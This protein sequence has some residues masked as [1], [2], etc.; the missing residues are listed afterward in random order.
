V[1]KRYFTVLSLFSGGMGLDIGLDKTGRFKHLACVEKVPAFCE[2]IR[3][4]RDAGRLGNRD[5][6]VY[7][8]DI[9]EMQPAQI[10]RDLQLVPGDLDLLVGGPPCQA[11]SVFGKRRGLADQRGQ[12][13]LEFLRFV[14]VLQPRA[15]LMENMR[16][17]LSMTTADSK[18]KG[19]LFEM[20]QKGFD[21][22][23]Y[24]SDCFVVNAVNYGAP[25]IRE[26]IL[27]I[28]NR[29]I[30]VADFPSP[31]HSD[32]PDDHLAPFRTLGDA[33]CGKPDPDPSVMQFSVR[34]QKYL[35]MVPAGGNWRS[36]PV[37][38]QKESM[39]KTFYLKGGRSAYWRKLS[40]EF[41]CPTVITMPNHAG[42]SMCHPEFLRPLTVG[43]CALVQEFPEGWAFAGTPGEKYQQVGN[44]V[45]ILLGRL[46]GDAVARL[47]D[48][49]TKGQLPDTGPGKPSQVV[50]IRPHV[51]TRW[52]WKDGEV[53]E[54]RPYSQRPR[55][56]P[57]GNDGPTLFDNLPLP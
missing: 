14:E 13:I 27:M 35:A 40:Y 57:R 49:I 54:A 15:F 17:L 31:M 29:G 46:A 47:L 7:Q 19:S 1:R 45:P 32:R 51:R 9:A 18:R 56:K 41:P 33:I 11:F 3:R 6:K 34:K 48:Q 5:L 37:E 53:I 24:R 28:G 20:V 55:R 16:G 39:G 44:A 26:R 8:Q 50:Q 52:W 12:L 22:I 23:G 4:N 21:S 2:T 30:A 10:M 38:I 36:L 25:Q 43:E 42:T